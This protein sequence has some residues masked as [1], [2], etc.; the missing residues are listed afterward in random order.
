MWEGD[1]SAQDKA[2]NDRKGAE[3]GKAP[4]SVV[5]C[6]ASYAHCPSTHSVHPHC[7]VFSN[8][9]GEALAETGDRAVSV[10][11]CNAAE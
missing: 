7:S 2:G 5:L 4:T 1:S 10:A 8:P 11:S 9:T 6:D 3:G